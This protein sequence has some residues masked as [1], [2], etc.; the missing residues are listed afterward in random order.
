ME[1]SVPWCLS[2][3]SILIMRQ[4]NSD[5][6]PSK[7]IIEYTAVA[8]ATY[9]PELNLANVFRVDASGYDT[10]FGTPKNPRDCQYLRL[11]IVSDENMD[12]EFSAAYHVNGAVVAAQTHEDN[13]LLIME[14]YY[15][16]DTSK[17]NIVSLG[18]LAA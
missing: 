13:V 18:V 14:G 9:Y 16:A 11:E 8:S 10:T 15:N 1:H 2:S 7:N 3:L 12:V 4:R 17:W 5:H 6:K